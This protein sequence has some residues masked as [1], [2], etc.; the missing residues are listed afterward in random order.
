VTALL[1]F[2]HVGCNA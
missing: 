2:R 1:A